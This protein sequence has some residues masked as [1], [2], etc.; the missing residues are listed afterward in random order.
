MA[1]GPK[2]AP[3]ET[4]AGI[5][6]RAA[7]LHFKGEL[8][9]SEVAA[10]LG[11]SV[12]RAHR[13]IAR[14]QD[15]GLVHITVDATAAACVD[16]ENALISRFGLGLC[17]VA[18]D[19]PEPG[20]IPL[21]A[22]GASGANW[23]GHVLETRAHTVIGVS[24]GRTIAAMVEA[25]RPCEAKDVV[26]VSLLGGLT[27]S[28]AA[29]PFDVIHRLAQKTGAESY[30]M[31]APLFVDTARDKELLLAQSMLRTAF[32]RMNRATLA[33]VGIGNLSTSVGIADAK[34]G[35]A[36]LINDLH[37]AGAVAEILGQF[38]DNEG[39]IMST[40]FDGRTM[41]LPLEDLRGREI[42]A[43]A[44]GESKLEAIRAALMSGLLTGLIID[45]ATARSLV[46]RLEAA[47][48]V[49]AE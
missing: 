40:P 15:L 44:G 19:L 14:A 4:D 21:R 9:Q 11:M 24:H 36:S 43:V 29:N 10:R 45:E 42:V 22:L 35:G 27:R 46:E 39:R 13:A 18:M 47:D 41:S 26:F 2:R 3:S 30:L 31:P 12:T 34:G 48:K 32:E 20:P 25:L 6:A 5:A 38:L 7:W 8:T 16:L 33:I 28:L 37:D 49:A 1:R 23:L 17:H